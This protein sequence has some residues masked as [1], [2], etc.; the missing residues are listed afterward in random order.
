MCNGIFLIRSEGLQTRSVKW[1][2]IGNNRAT[3]RW[4]LLFDFFDYGSKL[5]RAFDNMTKIQ[6]GNVSWMLSLN[7]KSRYS[8]EANSH[9][10]RKSWNILAALSA[11]DPLKKLILKNETNETIYRTEKFYYLVCPRISKAPK[12]VK[13]IHDTTLLNKKLSPPSKHANNS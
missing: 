1:V 3:I 9:E 8:F 6:G 7:H 5:L 2:F 13:R 11:Q 10:F 12:D 4:S